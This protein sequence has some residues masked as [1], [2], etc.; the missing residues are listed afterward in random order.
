M[1][2]GVG[3]LTAFLRSRNDR[4]IQQGVVIIV[5]GT[6]MFRFLRTTPTRRCLPGFGNSRCRDK[7]VLDRRAPGQQRGTA[8]RSA[9]RRPPCK[10]SYQF[11]W[12]FRGLGAPVP[13]SALPPRTSITG[14]SVS[15]CWYISLC[16]SSGADHGGYQPD[17]RCCRRPS[18]PLCVAKSRQPR[19][20]RPMNRAS[21]RIAERVAPSRSVDAKPWDFLLLRHNGVRNS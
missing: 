4:G 19:K 15:V 3:E 21:A 9:L 13:Q 14:E 12:G 2:D 18:R 5:V 16:A 11:Q 7:N 17:W 10:A 1:C 6:T 8:P 20:M